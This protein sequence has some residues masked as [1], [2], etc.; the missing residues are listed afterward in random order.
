MD[1]KIRRLLFGVALVA[2]MVLALPA[3]GQAD[4]PPVDEGVVFNLAWLSATIGF[5]LPLVISFFKRQ[6]WST[7]VKRIVSLFIA[8]V[9]GVVTVGFQAEWV[10]GSAS[11]FLQLAANSVVDIFVVSQVAY[12]SF[13]KD[14]APER[15][16]ENIGSGPAV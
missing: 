4:P 1:R 3:F 15:A 5:F 14:T 2:F 7:Q 6:N 13:W 10:F 11:D 16:L 9:V 8:A 12:L